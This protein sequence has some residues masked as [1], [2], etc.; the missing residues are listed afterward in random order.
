MTRIKRPA[1]ALGAAALLAFSLTA[2]GGGSSDAPDD[3]SEDEF[4]ET[5]NSI[6]ESFGE[7]GGEPTEEE[8]EEFQDRVAELADVGTPEDISEEQREGFEV[9]VDAIADADFDEIDM[10][11]ETFPGVSEEDNAKTEDFAN[12]AF[13]KC[14]ELPD[15]EDLPTE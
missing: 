10:E 3:A 13:E 6:F 12:Y 5:F 14:T 7:G 8:F 9:F 1:A 4:C 15:L 2:C 11:S